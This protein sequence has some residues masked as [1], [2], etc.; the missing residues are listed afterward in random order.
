MGINVSKSKPSDKWATVEPDLDSALSQSKAAE[1][2]KVFKAFKDEL[3]NQCLTIIPITSLELKKLITI[4]SELFKEVLKKKLE[5]L[6]YSQDHINRLTKFFLLKSK[7]IEGY[8]F[9]F[10]DLNSLKLIHD[11]KVEIFEE[12]CDGNLNSLDI[13]RRYYKKA[14]GSFVLQGYQELIDLVECDRIFGIQKIFLQYEE[15]ILTIKRVYKTLITG[16]VIDL[17]IYDATVNKTKEM[18]VLEYI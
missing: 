10:N 4:K 12:M 13:N 18:Q 7:A 9:Y 16:M 15:N 11:L 3:L 17:D 14:K 5:S 8:F 1:F 6:K 2:E